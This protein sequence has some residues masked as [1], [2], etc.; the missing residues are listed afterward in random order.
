MQLLRSLCLAIESS[1]PIEADERASEHLRLMIQ[2]EL[3]TALEF[4]SSKRIAYKD[5]R[6]TPAGHDFI[7]L[8]RDEAMWAWVSKRIADT[9]GTTSFENCLCLLRRGHEMTIKVPTSDEPKGAR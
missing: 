3:I 9:V 4:G 8:A 6:L 1:E 5:I 2:A 7:D